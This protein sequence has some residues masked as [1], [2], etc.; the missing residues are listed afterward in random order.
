MVNSRDS[1]T[2]M[3]FG[4]YQDIVRQTDKNPKTGL[5]GLNFPILGLFGE[6]GSVLSELKKKQ[7]DA[8][9]Y[10]GY[11]DSVIEEFGDAMWYFTNIADRADLNINTLAEKAFKKLKSLSENENANFGVFRADKSR[12][13]QKEPNISKEFEEAS[14]VL[15]GKVGRLLDEVSKGRIGDNRDTL[16]DRLVE[17]LQTM[18]QAAEFADVNLEN[19]VK[20][21]VGKITGRYPIERTYTSLFDDQFDS[22]EQIPRLIKMEISE[23]SIKNKSFVIQKCNGIKIGDRLTDNKTNQ[24]DYRFH[25]VFHLAYAAILGWSPVMRSLFKVKRK[26]NPDIDENEDGARAIL[27]EEGVA[28]WVFNHGLRLNNYAEIKTLDYGLL[29]A[30][31]ELVKGYEVDICPLWQ[32][33]EAILGGFKIFRFL[34]ENRRGV[35]IAD[36]TARTI[37]VKTL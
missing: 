23:R 13:L 5:S 30:I 1:K 16:S 14:I 18:V 22:D 10:I 29:K 36:L 3:Y 21:N 7:R 2:L 12:Y 24:D 31:S 4:K 28:T 35:V 9:S 11:A 26:S 19:A 37:K 17:I 25:D 6:V 32:W 33:E 8:D 34:K 15:A 20:K 27:I